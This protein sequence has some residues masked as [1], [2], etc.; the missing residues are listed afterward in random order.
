VKTKQIFNYYNSDISL[1]MTSTMENVGQKRTF[2]HKLTTNHTF[3]DT[4]SIF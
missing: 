2:I 3:L 4:I 1:E